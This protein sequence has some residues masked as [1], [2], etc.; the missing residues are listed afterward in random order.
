[1]SAGPASDYHHI[2]DQVEREHWWFVGLRE[3]VAQEVT[4]RLA[5]GSRILDV[6]CSTGH[7]IAEIPDTYERAGVD[8]SAGAIELARATRP[9]IRFVEASVDRLPF[10]DGS[11][12]GV[13]ACD[14]LSDR[15]VEDERVALREIRRVVRPGGLLL[16]Q[17]PAYE[18][19]K[20]DYDDV[21]A[22]AR[23]YNASSLRQLLQTGGFAVEHLTYRITALFPLAAVRRLV[24]ESRSGN[25]LRVPRPA[26][27][28]LLTRITRAENRMAAKRRLPFGLSVFAVAAAQDSSSAAT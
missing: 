26:A 3:F 23:R 7:V 17:L 20:G 12:D 10:E 6:G 15:G 2:L 8:I 16:V 21:V 9:D 22:T 28:R 19:L 18:W 5:S 14:V 24:A 25:D 27:N 11:F 13:L 1:M 4:T